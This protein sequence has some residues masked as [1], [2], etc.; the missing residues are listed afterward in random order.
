MSIPV[1]ARISSLAFAARPDRGGRDEPEGD[2]LQKPDQTGKNRFR[3][4]LQGPQGS[5]SYCREGQS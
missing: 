5:S 1:G 4:S 2:R 3:C